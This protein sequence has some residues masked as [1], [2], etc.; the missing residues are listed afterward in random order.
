MTDRVTFRS[1]HLFSDADQGVAGTIHNI[2]TIKE[3]REFFNQTYQFEVG[4]KC[5]PMQTVLKYGHRFRKH[6]SKRM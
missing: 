4:A 3:H 5:L 6:C 1:T 2:S